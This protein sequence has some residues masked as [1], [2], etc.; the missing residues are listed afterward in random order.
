MSLGREP[1]RESNPP[2]RGTG[3]VSDVF[4]TDRDVR[5]GTL[6]TA[7]PLAGVAC[8]TAEQRRGLK[9]IPGGVEPPTLR[10]PMQPI[11]S[12]PANR[13]GGEP[14]M[15]SMP[16]RAEPCGSRD[17][18]PFGAEAPYRSNS[19]LHH[20]RIRA[21]RAD[22]KSWG[23]DDFGGTPADTRSASRRSARSPRRTSPA[24]PIPRHDRSEAGLNLLFHVSEVSKIFTTS[25]FHHILPRPPM[26]GTD[27]PSRTESSRFTVAP[28]FAVEHRQR[29]WS[30]NG[31]SKSDHHVGS[32]R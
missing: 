6:E 21:S 27:V 31:Y 23:T 17:S 13:I 7:S 12:P 2:S 8:S 25:V 32:V 15:L 1:L 3:E 5:R 18:N 4:T 28:L 10:L 26:I 19:H 24:R 16:L 29:G 22:V 20:R 11:S 30:G 14:T 9:T